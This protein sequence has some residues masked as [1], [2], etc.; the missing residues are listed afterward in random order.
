MVVVPDYTAAIGRQQ[1]I[2][3]QAHINFLF[4]LCLKIDVGK[5]KVEEKAGDTRLNGSNLPDAIESHLCCVCKGFCCQYG[6]A[7]A[8]LNAASIRR[9]MR[10]SGLSDPLD[11]VHAYFGYLPGKVVLDACVYQGDRGC[12]LPR[13]MRGDMCN[14][15]RCKGLR[16]IDNLIRF[17][18][19]GRVFVAVR[20]DNRITRAAFV[21]RDK[22]RHYDGVDHAA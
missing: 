9:F 19:A 16:Q 11:I 17:N 12:T 18:R 14:A 21:T 2:R 20:K 8:F 22:I 3:V 10:L 6:K 15:Y 5:I 7:H 1:P 13:W 4:D